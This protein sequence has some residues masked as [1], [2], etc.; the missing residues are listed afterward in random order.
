MDGKKT[1][2]VGILTI[3]WGVVGAILGMVS[4]SHGIGLEE[5]G[6]IVMVGVAMLTG[7]QAIAKVERGVSR[8]ESSSRSDRTG[9]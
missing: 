4:D 2:F 1:Y 8:V 3:A 5:A 7:R 6:T 9:R